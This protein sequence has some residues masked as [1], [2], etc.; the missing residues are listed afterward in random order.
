MVRFELVQLCGIRKE[1]R[2][3]LRIIENL[4]YTKMDDD[5]GVKH[6]AFKY[7]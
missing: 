1:K 3:K 4:Y 6:N 5:D 7:W 2:E